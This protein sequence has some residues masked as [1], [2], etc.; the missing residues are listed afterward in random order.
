MGRIVPRFLRR[1]KREVY[2]AE[3]RIKGFDAQYRRFS[4]R[5]EAKE[6][7]KATEADLRRGKCLN[8]GEAK[9][10]TL[11]DAIERYLTVY[12][13][14]YPH[15]LKKH[16]QLLGWWRQKIGNL[17]LSEITPAVISELRDKLAAEE[18]CRLKI[19]SGSTVNRYLAALSKVLTLCVKEWCWLDISPMSRVGKLKENSGRTRYL[20]LEE[21]RRLMEACKVSRNKMLYDVVMI[22][23]T[24]GMRYSE[25]ISLKW[26]QIDFDKGFIHLYKTKNG[27]E[28]TVPIPDSVLELLKK[29]KQESKEDLVFPPIR[30]IS[31][32]RGMVQLRSS[33]DTATKQANI[34]GV[35]FHT[36][37]H[38]AASHFAMQGA[39][40]SALMSLLGHKSHSQSKRYTHFADAYLKEIVQTSTKTLF[41][42]K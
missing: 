6:W 35:T 22:A 33:F 34:Q 28:R 26:D 36:L 41:N 32:S 13:R 8:V 37:R 42:E 18:T 4:D 19:R 14:Q 16:S 11:S 21:I 12:L 10:H 9:R 40:T 5:K 30:R 24:T 1:E 23:L 27:T 17:R 31:N 3:V 2:D 15:R 38:T 7:I 20:S 39:N 25:I 29:R